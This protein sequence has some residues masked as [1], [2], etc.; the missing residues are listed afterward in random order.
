MSIPLWNEAVPSGTSTVGDFPDYGRDILSAIA[1]GMSVEH[2]WPGAGGGSQNSIGELLPG[3]SRAYVDQQSKSS[4]PGSQMTGRLFLAS[5]GSSGG[6]SFPLNRLF[7]YAST[8]TYLVGTPYGSEHS[9][10]ALTVGSAMSSPAN[11]WLR[12]SGSFQ[13]NSASGSTTIPFPIPY[14]LNPVCFVTRGDSGVTATLL[15][16]GSASTVNMASG[17]SALGATLGTIT[18]LWESLGLASSGSF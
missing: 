7:A 9:T 1:I 15:T 10:S 5:T 2:N 11:Y 18:V 8:G 16:A 3:A 13:T 12:Q 14:A 4:A 6:I 17:W